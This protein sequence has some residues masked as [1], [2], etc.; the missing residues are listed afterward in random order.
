MKKLM[1]VIMVVLMLAGCS[2]K[3]KSETAVKMEEKEP[4]AV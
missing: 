4:A 1:I 3:N 2:G